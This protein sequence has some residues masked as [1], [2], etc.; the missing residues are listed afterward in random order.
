MKNIAIIMLFIALT[1]QAQETLTL[2]QCREMALKN[3]REGAIAR[4]TEEKTGFDV[5]S[6]RA[7]FFPKITAQ[8]GYLLTNN[9]FN[10]NIAG[11]YLPTF[12]PDLTTGELKPN[13]LTMPDG[14]PVT[15]ADGNPVFRE[16]AYFPDMSLNFKLNGTYFAGLSAEQPIFMGGK[17]VSAYRMSQ[18]GREM[19]ALNTAV[20][21]TDIIVSTDEAYWLHVKALESQKVAIAFKQVID[22]LMRNVEAAIKVGMKTRNDLLKVQV[23]MNKADLQIQQAENA[24]RLSRMNLCQIIGKPLNSEF[25]VQSL[26]INDSILNLSTV[27]P[28]PSSRPE[29]SLLDRQIEL[30]SQQIRLVRSDF[31]PNIGVM[32]NYGYLHG[33]ELNGTP[34]V[35]KA[36]FSAMF[37]LRIPV[38]SWGEGLNKI[39]AARAERRIAEIQRD[40]LSEK[41]QLEILKYQDKLNESDMEITL[42]ARSLEQATENMKLSREHYETGMET[43]ASYLEA[44]TLWQQASLDHIN[45]LIS[46]HLYETYYLKATGHS[47]SQP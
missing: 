43:L 7:N 6:Y 37:T 40:D 2:D 21:R 47:P 22:E 36:S 34:L 23:Q 5:K 26:T 1:L 44:Q 31:L 32:A 20:T 46:R 28:S 38:F 4:Q 35:D 14:S 16:Y 39:R 18:I 33:P 9:R 45:A 42:T 30:K 41:M 10:K 11:N 24:I 15:G 29:Y 27:N 3:N 8:G 12:V 25:R 19:A 13:I 17:I